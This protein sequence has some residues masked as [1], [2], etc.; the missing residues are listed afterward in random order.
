MGVIVAKDQRQKLFIKTENI[1]LA[2]QKE[3]TPILSH[4]RKSI[5]Q[6]DVPQDELDAVCK[7]HDECWDAVVKDK[8][9]PYGLWE[10]YQWDLVHG[11]VL[12]MYI[13]LYKIII[14]SL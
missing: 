2:Y 1:K 3:L 9:C 4:L 10:H 6:G 11:Q 5:I 7:K 8:K 14:S 12:Y 13:Y